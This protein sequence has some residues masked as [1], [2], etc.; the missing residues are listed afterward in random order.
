M[1]F[2]IQEGCAIIVRYL[3]ISLNAQRYFL[4]SR[5]LFFANHVNVFHYEYRGC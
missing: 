3:L 5:A 1:L 4:L 2:G